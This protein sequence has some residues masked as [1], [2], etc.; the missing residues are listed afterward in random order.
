M[1]KKIY[2]ILIA[3]VMIFSASA[4]VF[5]DT[6][7]W[8]WSE[9]Y[10]SC[11]YTDSDGIWDATIT[12]KVTEPTCLEA[13]YTVYTATWKGQS[14]DSPKVEPVK[15]TDHS[16]SDSYLVYDGDMV[17]A[18]FKCENTD[19]KSTRSDTRF[20]P[21]KVYPVEAKA[22]T[23]TED[24]NIAY[25]ANKDATKIYLID[26][27]GSVTETTI[28]DVTIPKTGHDY[29]IKYDWA[30]NGK[31]CIAKA[32]CKYCDSIIKVEG[33]IAKDVTKEPT[34][35]EKGK[36]TYTAV[37][38]NPI[39]EN[40]TKTIEDLNYVYEP[41]WANDY[42]KCVA[43]CFGQ[44]DMD[45]YQILKETKDGVTTYTALFI[46]G[47]DIGPFSVSVENPNPITV[48]TKTVSIIAG[49]KVAAKKVFFVKNA[50]G[51]VTYK[52]VSG[53]KKIT[54]SKSG[55]ISVKKNLKKGT[56]KLKVKVSAAGNND[57]VAGSKT[58]TVKIK[59]K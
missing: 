44:P 19:C 55:K 56:Y 48:Q 53:N 30:A 46:I 15:A 4:F 37:F 58:V 12:A 47:G 11:T 26:T 29:Q 50:A 9:D 39:F 2:A 17:Y 18:I 49:K 57:F 10:K 23:C 32:S 25:Y 21:V 6:D 45:A 24:G 8:T 31:S 51:K 27:K 3:V 7:P 35:T 42:S 34:S 20:T 40:Q 43:K 59:V 22:A 5:A 52:K 28:A 38:S 41:S 33:D 13:G 1:G 16:W 54:I 14:I 36:T